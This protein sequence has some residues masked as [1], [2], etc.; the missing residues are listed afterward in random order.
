[1]NYYS[2][3]SKA[4]DKINYLLLPCLPKFNIFLEFFLHNST[5]YIKSYHYYSICY[6]FELFYKLL[7]LFS[8]YKRGNCG[9]C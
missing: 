4:E 9:N 7:L 3:N 8:G 6:I 2:L 1:M 5:F